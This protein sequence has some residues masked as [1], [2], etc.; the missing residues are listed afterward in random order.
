M[1]RRGAAET[2]FFWRNSLAATMVTQNN[3]QQIAA[4]VTAAIARRRASLDRLPFGKVHV[5]V[6]P[7][8]DLATFG[9]RLVMHPALARP[10]AA[11]E[12]ARAAETWQVGN[13]CLPL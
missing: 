12:Q 11:S 5:P 8:L 13:F 4:T 1:D 9:T 6:I 7:A 3:G 10:Y 2:V